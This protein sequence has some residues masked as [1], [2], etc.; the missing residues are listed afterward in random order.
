MNG[1]GVAPEDS[2]NVPLNWGLAGQSEKSTFNAN[3]VYQLPFGRGHL[4]FNNANPV[5]DE[6][7]NGWKLSG[8]VLAYT[9]FPNTVSAS[10]QG[11]QTYYNGAPQQRPMKLGDSAEASRLQVQRRPLLLWSTDSGTIGQAYGAVPNG[12][13]RNHKG[14]RPARAGYVAYDASAFKSFRVFREETLGFEV[15]AYNV[16]ES[17]ELAKSEHQFRFS[18]Q[19]RRDH[20][21]PR[22]RAALADRSEV[23]LLT[24]KG[25]A[26]V[27]PGRLFH[28][29]RRSAQARS[30]R[31]KLTLLCLNKGYIF[32]RNRLPIL[33]FAGSS[34]SRFLLLSVAAA[35]VSS[36]AATHGPSPPAPRKLLNSRLAPGR[37]KPTVV[38]SAV[39]SVATSP[40]ARLE[41]LGRAECYIACAAARRT[42]DPR[43]TG[44]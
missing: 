31:L 28:S 35:T 19:L 41:H 29:Q 24:F 10:S 42:G 5:I 36:Q 22:A 26:V 12:Q 40:C 37:H 43:W 14:G 4:L 38:L 23:Y 3:A 39:R 16:S 9:G 30:R 2:Y 27:R 18:R 21:R 7:I 33:A 17:R 13:L 11:I 25:P 34:L 20:R 8:V 6:V 1:T 32:L 15:D 44:A